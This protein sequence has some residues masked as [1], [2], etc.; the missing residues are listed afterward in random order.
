MRANELFMRY[1]TVYHNL[2]NNTYYY[3]LVKFVKE[4]I[5]N[6]NRQNHELI[7]II[8]LRT[9]YT[10]EKHKF[11]KWVLNRIIYFLQNKLQKLK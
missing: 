10:K 4:E 11:K 5:G 8:P 9:L 1:I 2:N 3:H 6:I 7:L